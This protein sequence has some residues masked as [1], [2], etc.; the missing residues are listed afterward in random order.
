MKEEG[1]EWKSH[2]AAIFK[3]ILNNPG[4]WVLATP[5][6]IIQHTLVEVGERAAELN[7]PI[8]NGLMCRLAIYEISDPYSKEFDKKKLD[9][10]MSKYEKAKKWKS[11]K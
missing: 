10:V 4:T 7:D 2:V 6:N 9:E 3:E 1:L 11:K 8:L 5:L